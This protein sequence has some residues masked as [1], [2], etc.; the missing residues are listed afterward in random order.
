M[1]QDTMPLLSLIIPHRN[2]AGVLPR[3]LDSIL[4]QSLKDLEVIIVDDC[5]DEGERCEDIAAAYRAKG[6]PV[7]LIANAT[8]QYT[9]NSRLIGVEASQGQVIGFADADDELWGTE[10]LEY[11][12]RLLLE[13]KA[14]LLHFAA[15]ESSPAK[16]VPHARLL[17][18]AGRLRGGRIFSA[19]AAAKLLPSSLWNKLCRRGLWEIILPQ[20]RQGEDIL[21]AEDRYL[22]SLLFFHAEHYVGSRRPGYHYRFEHRKHHK[23]LGRIATHYQILRML[24]PYFAQQ[25]RAG[26]DVHAYASRIRRELDSEL[27]KYTALYAQ[28]IS[29]ILQT[30]IDAEEQ[31][32]QAHVLAV[33]RTRGVLG[34]LHLGSADERARRFLIDG[35]P[36]APVFHRAF[37]LVSLHPV[38]ASVHI[39][40]LAYPAAFRTLEARL[41]E[42]PLPLVH[43]GVTACCLRAEDVL[44]APR[45][46][47]RPALQACVALLARFPLIRRRF[48]GCWLLA[49]SNPEPD[50]NAE[51]L[52]RWLRRM[53]PERKLFFALNKDSAAWARLEREGFHLLDPEKLGYFFAW[54]HCSWLIASEMAEYVIRPGWREH[55]RDM[56]RHQLCVLR[57]GSDEDEQPNYCESLVDMVVTAARREDESFAEEPRFADLYGSHSVQITDSCRDE[58]NCQLV[59]DA[60]CRLTGPV[61]P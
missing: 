33:D 60:L 36:S 6:L 3:L 57:R 51:H 18:L 34:L 47:E 8:R 13:T 55:Y 11:H 37:P 61:M 29:D 24:V 49:D 4:A 19:Y 56:V 14:D 54:V 52:Y 45:K 42:A 39:V 10:A 48:A 1:V 7:R 9:K 32:Q 28:R 20:A 16:P 31:R 12:V 40:W 50:G 26:R 46:P 30:W 43:G 58:G 2:H 23:R 22:T 25:D 44:V 5:S 17:P 38:L 27:G 21:F 35:A 53:H 59:Y 15:M 41:G